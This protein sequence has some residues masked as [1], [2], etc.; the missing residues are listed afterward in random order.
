MESNK[1]RGGFK[2]KPTG[3]VAGIAALL[4]TAATL[5]GEPASRFDVKL[6]PDKQPLHVLNR[7]AY[8][9][10]PGDVAEVRRVG[11]EAWIRQQ[12]NPAQLPENP[13]LDARLKLLTTVP[14]PTW[15]LF[16]TFQPQTPP[17][18]MNTQ[19][20]TQLLPQDQ[21]QKLLNSNTP[22]EER[23]AVIAPLTGEL[24]SKVL[25]AVPQ[26]M[27]EG[28]PVLKQEA[29]RARQIQQ[30]VQNRASMEQQRRLRPPLNEL[31][32]PE[33]ARDLQ[34]GTD[35]EKNSVITSLDAEKRTL[36]FRV[37]G[38][39]GAQMLPEAWRR[40]ALA[41]ANPQQAVVNELIEAKLQRAVLSNRQLEEVLVDFWFNHF[42]VSAS[43]FQVRM[44]LPSYEREAIRPHVLGRFRDMLLATARHPA[45]LFYLDNYQSQAPRPEQL[46]AVAAGNNLRLP[47][48]NENYGRELME[49]HTLGVGGGYTQSDVVNVARAFTGWTIYDMNRIGEF[50]FNPTMHDRNEKTVLGRE[51]PRGGG[52]SEGVQVIDMLAK[53]PSTARFI[54]RKLAQRFVADE[55]PPA[56]VERMAATFTKTDG[57]LRAV[58]ETLLLS[59]E[60]LSEG[61]WRTKMKSPLEMVAGS[62]RV[63]NA[64][65]TDITALA[66]R[67]ADLGQ[68]LYAKVEPTGYPNTGE[69]WASSAGLLARMNFATALLAGQ[70]SGVKVSPDA[71]A[72]AGV[73]RAMVEL[74]GTEASAD[75][76]AAVDK[77]A[78]GK[79]PAPALVATVLIGS[80]DFQKR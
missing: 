11:V 38:Q 60:F 59:K 77:G 67:V 17:L 52:E 69:A 78:E 45:M 37:L 41:L 29:E 20:I 9:P 31:L 30:E 56:L 74:T 63:L 76:I 51:F 79:P 22:L 27:L 62:L 25:I 16:E 12:L 64:E 40:E 68:P 72:A 21:V 15:Q 1:K 50:Q 34:R 23:R 36:V 13:A 32:T 28:L 6:A 24:R 26:Q 55:P 80:P 54:S 10:R 48:I 3:L 71:I 66:Q 2:M 73:R 7:L 65:I 5:S 49:L 44:L 8:G 57:D 33:Q 35:E 14:M 42:N 53:H 46:Q 43:K 70:I 75:A 19:S 39:Q 61:A 58:M 4:A 18:M 47:G